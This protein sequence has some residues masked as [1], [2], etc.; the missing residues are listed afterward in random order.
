MKPAKKSENL[1]RS[2]PSIESCATGKKAKFATNFQA[3]DPLTSK[4]AT[5]Q[6]LKLAAKRWQASGVLSFSGAIGA[7]Q[8][9]NFTVRTLKGNILYSRND[10]AGSIKVMF[11]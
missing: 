6:F 3:I 1:Q 4:P 7:E 5:S 8:S 9:H 2:E 11:A 10:T